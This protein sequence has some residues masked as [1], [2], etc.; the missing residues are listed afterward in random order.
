MIGTAVYN[1]ES[2]E[3]ASFVTISIPNIEISH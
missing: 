2:L 1:S 3:S